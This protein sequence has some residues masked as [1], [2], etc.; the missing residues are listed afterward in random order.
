[1]HFLAVW[2]D[3]LEDPFLFEESVSCS[4]TQAAGFLHGVRVSK[5]STHIYNTTSLA[6][7][8]WWC[9]VYFAAMQIFILFE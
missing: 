9:L 6:E 3:I 8:W 1:M 2:L 5:Q 7:W 4:H